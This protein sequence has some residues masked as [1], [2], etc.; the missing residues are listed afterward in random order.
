M[1]KITV[2]L[3]FS[4]PASSLPYTS[5]CKNGNTYDLRMLLVSLSNEIIQNNILFFYCLQFMLNF[6]I[7]EV[8][9]ATQN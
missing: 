7:L 9:Y 3:T 5:D 6:D 4:S 2:K 1:I 8:T